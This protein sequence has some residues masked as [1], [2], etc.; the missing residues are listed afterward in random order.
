M[1][2][3]VNPPAFAFLLN[4]QELVA[5]QVG[6]RG[7]LIFSLTS[8]HDSRNLRFKNSMMILEFEVG[9]NDRALRTVTPGN[10]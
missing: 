9:D 6:K 3:L 7:A 5:H 4:L 8:I 2:L 10:S 1:H